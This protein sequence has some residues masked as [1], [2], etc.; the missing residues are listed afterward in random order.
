MPIEDIDRIKEKFDVVV[1]SL[2]LHYVEDFEG[3]V[4]SV[5]NLLTPGGEALNVR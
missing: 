1:S 4:K 5:N 2:A 3:V